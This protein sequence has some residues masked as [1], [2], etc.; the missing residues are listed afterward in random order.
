M[1]SPLT[2]LTF[3]I[4]KE[5][6]RSSQHLFII[7]GGMAVVYYLHHMGVPYEG[8]L[9][10]D[11]DISPILPASAP[12]YYRQA[13]TQIERLAEHLKHMYLQELELEVEIIEESYELIT[14]K[15]KH[16]MN[17]IVDLSIPDPRDEDSSFIRAVHS[18]FTSYDMFAR[19]VHLLELHV[20]PVVV[21]LRSAHYSLERYEHILEVKVYEWDEQLGDIEEEIA[22]LNYLLETG[23][24]ATETNVADRRDKLVSIRENL[25]WQV[26]PRYIRKLE[27]KRNRLQT[28]ISKLGEIINV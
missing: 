18:V 12:D 10:G 17:A 23:K 11:I 9:T 4:I 25:R 1:A 14:L 13:R 2:P 24:A 27:D 28:K 16:T 26:S 21:E 8:S 20:N 22:R 6:Y 19:Y 7:K 5:V 3:E 15:E